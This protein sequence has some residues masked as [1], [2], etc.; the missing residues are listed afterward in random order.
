[1]QGLQAIGQK[2]LPVL[3]SVIELVGKILFVAV[4]IPKFQY[5]AVIFC[6]PVIWC[7]MIAELLPAFW[8]NPFI[9]TGI[10]SG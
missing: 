4:L 8:C 5:M 1:M 9:R 7:F 3:S 2:I 10:I 6:E